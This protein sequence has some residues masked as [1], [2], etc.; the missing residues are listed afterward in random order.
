MGLITG[1]C[2]LVAIFYA[3]NDLSAI[4]NGDSICPLGDIYLQATG[5]KAGAVGLLVLSICPIFCATVG[6][7]IT[8]GRTFYALGRGDA[9]PFSRHIGAISPTWGS[10]FYSTLACGI[11]MTCIGAIY[12]GSLTAFN[13]FIGSYAVLTTVSYLLAILPHV[14]T[15]RKYIRPGPFS[16]GR[17]GTAVN[18][19]ACGYIVVTVVVFCFPYTLPVS[20]ESMNYTCVIVTGLS[21]L[22]TLW[23]I[24]HGRR[25]YVG[26]G[27]GLGI[28]QHVE[29]K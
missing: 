12:V 16:L 20:A 22:V 24:V 3:T 8:T 10:P 18:L 27:M 9:T 4:I 15:G 13:A 5:S 28:D 26:P 2:Y 7:Y 19:V 21:V 29:E 6:C 23:W 17:Y 1:F 14:L 11:F 25:N